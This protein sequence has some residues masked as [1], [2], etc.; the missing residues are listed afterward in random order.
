MLWSFSVT[1]CYSLRVLYSS[2][3]ILVVGSFK[4]FPECVSHVVC[5]SLLLFGITSF[6]QF[7]FFVAIKHYLSQRIFSPNTFQ[8]FTYLKVKMRCF[9]NCQHLVYLQWKWLATLNENLKLNCTCCVMF[10]IFHLCSQFWSRYFHYEIIWVLFF[11]H[12]TIWRIN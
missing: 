1:L 10:I 8:N 5:F 4:L 12:L 9:W 7:T 6:S 11:I 3:E 2:R